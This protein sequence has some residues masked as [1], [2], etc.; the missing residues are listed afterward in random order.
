MEYDN[1]DSIPSCMFRLSVNTSSR[2]NART[3]AYLFSLLAF[4][5]QTFALREQERQLNMS[6]DLFLRFIS[7]CF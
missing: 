5:F 3:S 7:C 4:V 2:H 1:E 6:F